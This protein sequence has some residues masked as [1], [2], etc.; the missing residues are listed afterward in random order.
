[1]EDPA[2]A[3]RLDAVV[4]RAGWRELRATGG[5]GGPWASGVEVAL[6]VQ[7]L[8]RGPADTALLGPTLAAELRRRAGAPA[9]EEPETVLLS[10]D[11]AGI[12]TGRPGAAP[13]AVDAHR[14]TRALAVAPAERGWALTCS[15]LGPVRATVD[16]TRPTAEVVGP[17]TAVA[18]GGVALGDEDLSCVGALGRAITCADLVGAMQ[19]AT[20]LAVG[21]VAERHQYG[22]PVGSFQAVQHLLAD[23]HVLTEGSRSA[24]LHAAWAVDALPAPDAVAATAVAKAYAARAARDVCEA[25]IQAHGGIGNTWECMAHVYLRR[26][27]ASIDL[28]GG[29]GPNLERVLAHHGVAA[30]GAGTRS[31]D[32]LR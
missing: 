29:E 22:R 32:G 7:E 12:S 17:A 9:A 3:A 30:A 5:D 21:Y 2:R 11:L 8:A 1:L 15:P 20:S 14:A 26:A 23:A 16:L 4:E 24:A 19:G 10:G 31:A 28:L 13:V 18:G 25:S 27:L 6:V